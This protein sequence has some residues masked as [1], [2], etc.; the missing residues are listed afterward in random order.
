MDSKDEARI[1]ALENKVQQLEENVK[2]Q[3]DLYREVQIGDEET[4]RQMYIMI[5]ALE[6][7][8]KSLLPPPD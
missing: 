6:S 8:V 2:R 1:K 7:V 4:I 3:L 5:H